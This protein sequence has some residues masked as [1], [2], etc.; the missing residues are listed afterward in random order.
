M[1][2]SSTVILYSFK[3]IKNKKRD[4][5]IYIYFYVIIIHE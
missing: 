2:I 4:N 1:L 3:Q 5:N